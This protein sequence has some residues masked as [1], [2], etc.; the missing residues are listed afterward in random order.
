MCIFH[1]FARDFAFLNKW[2]SLSKFNC[3]FV[4]HF[5]RSFSFPFAQLYSLLVIPF[6]FSFVHQLWNF[7]NYVHKMPMNKAECDKCADD[8][9]AVNGV[10]GK[11]LFRIAALCL[12][13]CRNVLFISIGN[14]YV[15]FWML[16]LLHTCIMSY[17]FD[18]KVLFFHSVFGFFSTHLVA[19]R[20]NSYGFFFNF[21]LILLSPSHSLALYYCCYFLFCF[22][23]YLSHGFVISFLHLQI[24]D[25]VKSFCRKQL[26]IIW[27]INLYEGFSHIALSFRLIVIIF[28]R[29][30]RLRQYT[31]RILLPIHCHDSNSLNMLRFKLWCAIKLDWSSYKQS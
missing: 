12:L 8:G 14:V 21:W 18:L 28:M 7:A 6:A 2:F 19:N 24:P 25:R 17:L 23:F 31:R 13:P 1:L 10:N 29:F 9:D 15:L 22:F 16:L 26:Q 30:I 5:L 20:H 11:S 4:L 3:A 27:K